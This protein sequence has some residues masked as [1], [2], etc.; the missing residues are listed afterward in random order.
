MQ[1]TAA[2]PEET[3]DR[4]IENQMFPRA[5]SFFNCHLAWQLQGSLVSCARVFF[6]CFKQACS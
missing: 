1:P 4:Y 2:S 5:S 6:A 3:R